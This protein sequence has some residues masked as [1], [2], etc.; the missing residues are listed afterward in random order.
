MTA[1]EDAHDATPLTRA[2]LAYHI[3]TGRE[4]L[5]PHADAVKWALEHAD[6]LCDP[7][8]IRA[9]EA[10]R[11]W[12]DEVV[13]DDDT[14]ARLGLDSDGPHWLYREHMEC[15][16]LYLSRA[17]SGPGAFVALAGDAGWCTFDGGIVGA[18]VVATGLESGEA[19]RLAAEAALRR[20]GVLAEGVT[21]RRA[22]GGA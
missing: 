2:A 13:S 5:A 21:V 4:S 20:A 7:R 19:G 6:P 14:R 9:V 18:N 15:D 12:L 1:F 10:M 11:L 22:G 3:A 17:T 16:A 8:D